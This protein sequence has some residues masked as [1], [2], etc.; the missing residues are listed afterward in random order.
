MNTTLSPLTIGVLGLGE[1]RS[2]ISAT[3]SSPYWKLGSICDLNEDLC[4]QRCK[5]FDLENYTL[6][7]DEMLRDPGIDVIAIYT[8]DQLH[9]THILMALK[10]GK[11]V[12]CIKLLLTDLAD[13]HELLEA[14]EHSG[15][16]VFVGQSSRFYESLLRQRQDFEAGKLGD[17]ITVEAQYSADLRWFLKKDMTDTKNFQFLYGCACHPIDLVRWYFPNVKEVMGYGSLSEKGRAAGLTHPDTMHLIM[18]AACDRIA[19]VSGAYSVTTLP[20]MVGGSVFCEL[21]GE[22]GSSR[23]D[24]PTPRYSRNTPPDGPVVFDLSAYDKHFFRFRG[25]THHAGEYQNYMDYFAECLASGGRPKQ[26][27]REGLVTIAVMKA[28]EESFETG[29]PVEVKTVLDRYQL[30]H[31]HEA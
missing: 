22:L 6:D 12:I 24:Y 30:G 17:L 21:R 25:S 1:G 27:I 29:K 10:A 2:S 11:H 28:F 13:A 18:K 31:L 26:D 20:K 8:P 3:L 7:Y 9:L 4:L 14:S 16:H 5:E 23:A 19:R 15:K